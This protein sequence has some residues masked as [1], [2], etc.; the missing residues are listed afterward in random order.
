VEIEL[1]LG[2]GSGW[3]LGWFLLSSWWHLAL[4]AVCESGSWADTQTD[5]LA[6]SLPYSSTDSYPS[7]LAL[8]FV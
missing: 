1:S 7:K 3:Q 2:I 8:E 6:Y 4:Q 5:S